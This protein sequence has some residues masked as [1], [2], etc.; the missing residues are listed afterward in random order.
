MA[1]TPHIR[2]IGAMEYLLSKGIL[3]KYILNLL[4]SILDNVSN[5]KEPFCV[6]NLGAGF[7]WAATPEGHNY[8][9]DVH[10]DYLFTRKKMKIII[11]ILSLIY[12]GMTL[13]R[14]SD[15]RNLNRHLYKSLFFVVISFVVSFWFMYLIQQTNLED[16]S[17][18]VAV[19]VFT[20]LMTALNKFYDTYN[21]YQ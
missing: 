7:L 1:K 13:L 2:K 3:E 9:R 17:G 21:T 16:W 19:V 15:F 20:A 5:N 4:N 12:L 10:K 6:L 11:I 14:H 8:W 18:V